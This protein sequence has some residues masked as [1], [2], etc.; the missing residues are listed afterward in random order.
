VKKQAHGELLPL[1]E[2][3][4]VEHLRRVRGASEH[5]IRAYR[6][7]LRL[8]FLFLADRRRRSVAQLGLDD[9]RVDSVLA[10]LD[11][12][13]SGRH[14]CAATR[15]CRRAAIRGFVQHLLRHDIARAGQYQRILAIPSKKSRSRPAAYF[16]P[17]EAKM[18]LSQPDRCTPAGARDHALL[19]FLYNTGTR[20]GEALAVRPEDLRLL[21]PRHVRLL[22]K[23]RKERICPLWSETAVALR[24]LLSR[25]GGSAPSE[26]IFRSRSGTPL[27][28]DGVAYILRKHM[29]RAAAAMPELRGRRITPHM[30]RHSCAV[31]LLQA[32]VDVTVIRDYLGHASIATTNRYISTNQETRRHVL[33]AFWK[34]A[35]LQSAGPNS[36]RPGPALLAFLASL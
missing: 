10:F 18:L 9:V 1:V 21:R 30:L 7:T 29:A 25:P 11:H 26:P 6:D 28:R 36:W 35:G 3:W 20:V 14:N 24:T 27:T 34:R 15:N 19:L 23:G 5:T 13:E 17:A 2:T 8:F 4:F 12:V 33:Q 22:G 16:E 32:G 31:A